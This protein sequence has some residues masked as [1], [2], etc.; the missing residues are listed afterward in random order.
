LNIWDLN[1]KQLALQYAGRKSILKLKHKK[2]NSSFFK[3]LT[4]VKKGVEKYFNSTA[5]ERMLHEC[6][7]MMLGKHPLNK[8]HGIQA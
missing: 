8:L 3:S 7:K 6:I 2:N 5:E 1:G 4:K